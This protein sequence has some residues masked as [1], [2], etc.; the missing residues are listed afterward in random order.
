MTSEEKEERKAIIE[1][2]KEKKLF[3]ELFIEV[4]KKSKDLKARLFILEVNANKV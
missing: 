3:K 1:A 4:G 2:Y